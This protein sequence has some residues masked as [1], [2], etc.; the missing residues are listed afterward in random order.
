M[1][2]SFTNSSLGACL[3]AGFPRRWPPGRHW[4]VQ[5]LLAA[6]VLPGAGGTVAAQT[7]TNHGAQVLVQ[8]GAALVVRGTVLNKASSTLTNQG[9]VLLTGDLTNAGTLASAGW[10][11]FAGAADQT[12]AVGG[13][14]VAQLE[15]RNTGNVGNNR[16]LLPQDLTITSQL[17]LT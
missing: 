16:V 2:I 5:A 6:L 9:T 4:R 1:I 13:G 15:A 3:L 11:V 10:L 14:S 17:L 12:F 8:A 7:L